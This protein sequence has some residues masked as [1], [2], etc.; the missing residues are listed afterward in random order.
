MARISRQTIVFFL[1]LDMAALTTDSDLY[2]SSNDGA[3]SHLRRQLYINPTS[4]DITDGK[5]TQA[6]QTKG[7]FIVQ[8]WGEK[9]TTISITGTTG[10]SGIEGINI[11]RSIYRHEQI[12]MREILAERQ[13]KIA[14]N[15]VQSA[16][17]SALAAQ[18]SSGAGGTLGAIADVATGGAFSR[19]VDGF[20]NAIDIITDPFS[21]AG[22]SSLDRRAFGSTPTMA[23]LATNIDM[24]Y[25]GEYFRGY[26]T[27]FTVK[28]SAQ[29]QGLF[30]YTLSFTVTRRT[31][32]RGNFMRW[33]RNPYEYDGET[34]MAPPSSVSKNLFPE[35][36]YL[37][38]P[39]ETDDF[40][41]FIYKDENMY[42][43][44]DDPNASTGEKSKFN[45]FDQ[46]GESNGDLG[47]NR[48]EKSKKGS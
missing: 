11:L 6:N 23:A 33:H 21:G 15:T 46:G 3:S 36:N 24:F 26:F 2:S 48:R 1:P 32:Y 18:E 13:R 35:V 8:Y 30:T 19:A 12:R 10:S 40:S 27:D 17:E 29:E 7:G 16:T 9:L 41:S 5:I 31:G 47:V 22:Q 45:P 37:S 28:E 14:Q 38:F 25:Q 34:R 20:S 4:F 42:S 44:P 43:S 39:I